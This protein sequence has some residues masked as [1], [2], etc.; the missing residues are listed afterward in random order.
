MRKRR[1]IA[2]FSISFLDLLSGAL[3]AVI[4]LYVAIP[5]NLPVSDKIEDNSSV[6]ILKELKASQDELAKVKEKLAETQRQLEKVPVSVG[7]PVVQETQGERRDLDIG[8]KFK[9]KNIV[10]AIDTS[11]SMQEEDR[12]GQ[13]KAGI[14]MLFT[15]LPSTYRID[16]VK[17]PDGERAPFKSLFGTIKEANTANKLDTFDFVYRMRP[18][19]GTPT[20]DALL[21]ILK[22]YD[23]ISDIVL[24]SDGAPSFHNSNKKDDIYDILKVVRENNLSKVQISTMGVGSDFIKDQ[25]SDRYKF[26]KSLAEE[27]NGFFVGF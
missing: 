11:L 10:F 13:V 18:M 27:N 16:V 25:T 22:N 19:G 15:S 5:K 12:M 26:L 14:K 3:G 8:F 7:S 20:R 4:I 9:G 21:F 6:E 23:G 1:E 2:L 24:L 17:Y